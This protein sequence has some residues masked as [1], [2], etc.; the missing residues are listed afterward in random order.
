[1]LNLRTVLIC[2]QA[3]IGL[4]VIVSLYN[5]ELLLS[6]PWN[7]YNLQKP[8]LVFGRYF[9]DSSAL[10][11]FPSIAL[12]MSFPVLI[13]MV[14]SG[15]ERIGTGTGQI[16]GANTFGAILG[17]LFTGFLFLPRLGAQ[18][19]LLLI[20]TLNLLMMMYLFR[21][22]EYFTKTLRK[23]MTVV[24]AGVILV[25][26]IGLPSD[27]LDRFFLRD[28]SG[29]KDFQKLLYFEEGLTDT[30]AV[31]KDDYGILDPDA[32]RLVTNGVSMSA[33]NFIAS[34][35]MKLLAHL[36]IMMVDNPEK[37]LVVCFGTGQTTG[38]ASI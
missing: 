33:V 15:Y 6:A 7:G 14:S 19:S 9:S 12:G 28:S 2:L 24:L 36:P 3:S 25:I 1:N 8:V 34:R 35:Y 37:V 26:N 21:T 23:M 11:L 38:A 31:F 18:Q 4:Y 32:K 16:Y 20:A 10:M 30:V 5:M 29:Q 17:S 27:L 13:K 22:G